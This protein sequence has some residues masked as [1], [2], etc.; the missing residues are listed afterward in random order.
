MP[1]Q[2][3]IR[4]YKGTIYLVNCPRCG[5]ENRKM[6]VLG[7]AQSAMFLATCH[8]CGLEVRSRSSDFIK[9]IWNEDKEKYLLR[10]LHYIS[11][12]PFTYFVSANRLQIIGKDKL[13]GFL[14]DNTDWKFDIKS[15][16]FGEEG[17][18]VGREGYV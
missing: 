10:V 15:C 17:Y 16:R 12:N 14:E 1:T 7:S 9:Y 5:S 18:I 6:Y 13:I 3:K 11:F 8:D 4:K 2:T